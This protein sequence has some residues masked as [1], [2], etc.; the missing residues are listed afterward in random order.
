[1]SAVFAL[2]FCQIG[3]AQSA[4]SARKARARTQ[5][6]APLLPKVTMIDIA[7]LKALLKPN[8]K[9]LLINVWATWCDPCREEF[10]DLVKIDAEFRGRI[11]FFVIS[12][13]DLEEIKRGVPK[14]LRANKAEMPAYLLNTPDED[15]AITSLSPDWAGS[16]PLTVLFDANGNITYQRNGR[17]RLETLRE[18]I[19]KALPVGVEK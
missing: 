12:V 19:F 2:I 13:D 5:K 8:G 15:A 18:N 9:P 4:G 7:G 14:F 1:M 6:A 17:V 11:N 3:V 16:L 10:P